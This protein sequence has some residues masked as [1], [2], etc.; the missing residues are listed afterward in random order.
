MPLTTSMVRPPVLMPQRA[1][2]VFE[3]IV[4]Q[5]LRAF[6]RLLAG[7]HEAAGV[8]HDLAHGDRMPWRMR[9]LV[10][11]LDIRFTG[12]TARGIVLRRNELHNNATITLRAAIHDVLIENNILRHSAKGIVGDLWQRQSGVLLRR[13]AFE[14]VT[15]PYEPV[16]AGYL[17]IEDWL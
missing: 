14:D 7:E 10:V 4:L 5:H 17:K 3:H 8:A 6:Q 16:D 11:L 15:V 13:N 2:R 12:T 1:L 9:E